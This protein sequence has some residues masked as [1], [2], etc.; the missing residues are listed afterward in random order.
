MDPIAL[1]EHRAAVNPDFAALL[2]EFL[3]ALEHHGSF[4]LGR[5]YDISYDE[6][7]ILLGVLYRWRVQRFCP[8]VFR[9]LRPPHESDSL[10]R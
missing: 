1:A 4:D 10:P 5:L 7:E 9:G 6:F 2:T 8:D 3:A